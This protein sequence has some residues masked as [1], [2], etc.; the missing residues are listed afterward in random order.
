MIQFTNQHENYYLPVI[1]KPKNSVTFSYKPRTRPTRIFVMGNFNDWNRSSLPLSDEDGDG[2][3]TREVMLDDGV[4]EYQFVVDKSE[5]F[6]PLN[7]EKTDNGF[8]YF[9]SVLRV[10][11][12]LAD[13]IPNLYIL[14][15]RHNDTLA[16]TVDCLG[17]TN[18]IRY[19]LLFDNQLC[20]P[21]NYRYQNRK[22]YIDLKAFGI[23][24]GIHV[25]RVTAQFRNQP[26]NVVTIYLKNGKPLGNSTFIW[27]DACL[28]AL[29]TDRFNNGDPANDRPV[30]NPQIAP[31]ANFQGGDF[32]GIR[33]KI[34]KGYFDSLGVNTLWISPVNK[35][36]DSAYQEWPEPHNYFSGYHGYWPIDEKH[37]DSRFGTLDDFRKLV[38][39]AHRH[40]IKILLDFVSNHVHAEHHFY[41][42]HH[43]WF[44]KLELPDGTQNIR[45]WDEYRLTTWFDTFIPSFDYEVSHNA[46]QA[47]TDNAVWWLKK[48]GVDGF[49]HDATKHV[50][51]EFWQ[52]LTH[53]IK[54]RVN[55]HR[56]LDVFQIGECFGSNDLI[57]SYVNN[58][59]LE[60]QFNFNQFFTARRTFIDS[61]GDFRDLDL[62]I[63][64]AL[65]VY[66]YNHLMGNLMDSHDQV[67]MMAFLDGD[68]TLSDDG[69]ARAWREP[70][71]VVDNLSTYRKELVVLAYILTIP[72]IPVI[73][74][75][76]EFGLT[77]ANDPDNRRMMRFGNELNSAEQEQL[78]KVSQLIR[79]RNAHPALRRGDY[80]SIK[81]EKDLFVYS[82]G[83]LNERLIVVLNK[84]AADQNLILLLPNWI[85]G[86][87]LRSLINDTT[88][89]IEEN[90]IQ[91]D[92][93]AYGLD[94]LKV[95]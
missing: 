13:R 91:L 31:Q 89:P 45:R 50:P 65:E 69:A 58:S 37:T 92:V 11:A 34:E 5:I 71:I 42:E 21:E 82:R 93:P 80:L 14:P 12:P 15:D 56:A 19:F 84:G 85:E 73:D 59:M 40:N 86:R 94:I 3:Y 27:N 25:L 79:L 2:V 60:S 62:S 54:N 83:D 1:V 74:Y 26:G 35:T 51:Y 90:T 75:G 61:K 29:M 38:E 52:T 46:L 77:G 63:S 57:K 22:L 9:N 20:P 16:L 10:R 81:A 53:K 66:G 24:T 28:Y 30:T 33:Q 32:R 48:T 8:G 7:P 72:G 18:D 43:D 68:L 17:D 70:A 44:G 23:P 49:R 41:K 47:M 4:Y 36:T 76:D 87:A 95:E 39:T 67:R 88:Q 64:K 6:D 55:P 78:H